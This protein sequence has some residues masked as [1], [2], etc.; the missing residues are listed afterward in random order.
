MFCL[1]IFDNKNFLFSLFLKVCFQFKNL[2]NKNKFTKRV[3]KNKITFFCLK[4]KRALLNTLKINEILNK[5][6]NIMDVLSISDR[7]GQ[8]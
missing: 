4:K 5:N 3:F 8:H 2:E 7:H 1:K 6:I